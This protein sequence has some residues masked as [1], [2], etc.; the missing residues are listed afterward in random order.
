[1]A[2]EIKENGENRRII[3]DTENP[4]IYREEYR[5]KCCGAWIN[6][7]DVVWLNPETG[8]LTVEKGFPYHSECVLR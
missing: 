7:D 1:M 8:E 5:C 6:E 3:Y 2:I 4:R